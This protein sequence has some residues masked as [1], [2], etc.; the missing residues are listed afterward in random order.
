MTGPEFSSQP[1]AFAPQW[2]VVGMGMA[3]ASNKYKYIE[4]V[5]ANYTNHALHKGLIVEYAQFIDPT[6]KSL[7]KTVPIPRANAFYVGGVLALHTAYLA[8]GDALLDAFTRVRLPVGIPRTA[9]DLATLS[10]EDLL[11][12]KQKQIDAIL[13]VGTVGYE[14]SEFAHD[15]L[16]EWEDDLVPDITE[17]PY[18]RRGF[19]LVMYMAHNA[20]EICKKE[21]LSD[22]LA[23]VELGG[24]NWDEE[25]QNLRGA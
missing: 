25:L 1:D 13:Q 3:L 7:Y 22:L 8:G 20:L 6:P 15:K 2:E 14:A 21:D 11:V 10:A 19:G 24:I 17:Q 18:L 5:A 4:A 9:E 12:L 23:A 16:S